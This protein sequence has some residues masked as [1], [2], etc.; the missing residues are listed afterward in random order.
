MSYHPIAITSG[1]TTI[2]VGQKLNLVGSGTSVGVVAGAPSIITSLDFTGN[3]TTVGTISYGGNQVWN[4]EFHPTTIAGY[5]ITDAQ[6][7]ST[8]LTALSGVSSTGLYVRSAAGTIVTRSLSSGS[9][10]VTISQGDGIAGNP[11][12]DIAEANLILT[13]LGGTLSV[14]KGGTGLTSIGGNN[15]ILGVSAGGSLEYKTITA[16]A[17]IT[18]THT[19]STITLS[20][21]VGTVTS[22]AVSAANGFTGS[23]TNASTTPA[24]TLGTSLTGLLKGTGSSLSVATPGT[25]YLVSLTGDITTSSSVA[26]LASVNSSPVTASFVK[27]TNNAKGL[28]TATTSVTA[29]DIT[30]V[31]GAQTAKTVLAAPTGTAG[32]PSFRTL[33][34]VELND[35]DILSPATNQVLMY[36]NSKW[37]NADTSATSATTVLT[38]WVLSGTAYH[39][40]FVHNLGTA[41]V[42]VATY[43]TT[44]DTMVGVDSVKVV[45]ANTVRIQI[46]SNS[47]SIRVVVI[48]NGI[49]VT[50]Q[51]TNSTGVVVAKNGADV[52]ASAT[53]LNFTGYGFGVSSA[54]SGVVNV[55]IGSRFTYFAPSLESPVASDWAVNANATMIPDST[56]PSILVRQFSN[57]AEQGV[58]MM[59]TV[60][61]GATNMVL[62]IRGKSDTAVAASQIQFKLYRRVVPE[63]AAVGAW[64]TSYDL[65]IL[66]VPA[67][68]FFQSYVMTVPISTLSMLTDRSYQI[69]LTR[70]ASVASNLPA[71]FSMVEV[72]VEFN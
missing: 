24:I 49:T 69:E 33:G 9:N 67:N 68:N 2:K 51:S 30:T 36:N 7:K 32:T 39:A 62:R 25:D 31:L 16:G 12:I 40:D 72:T 28:V 15:T 21:S 59:V 42:V 20:S 34:L 57:S 23:V 8:E 37:V 35:V 56:N 71:T 11:T 18:V 52:V 4:Q 3:I 1:E 29:S 43:D 6:S 14:A 44:D 48:A 70:N 54:G 47:A 64:S 13:N 46:K 65:P 63:N 5:G 66:A 22:V 61:S 10:K 38:S 53:K 19:A 17:G 27:I 50:S 55:N 60:P 26:T 58:G 41:N 45:D